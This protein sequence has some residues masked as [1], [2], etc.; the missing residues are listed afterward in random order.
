MPR[1]TEFDEY[2]EDL[3]VEVLEPEDDG[4]DELAAARELVA[5][6]D[7]KRQGKKDSAKPR[8]NRAQRRSRPAG[9]P[10][11]TDRLPKK[12]IRA[13]ETDPD[14]ELVITLFDREY[15]VRRGDL[16]GNWDYL[17]A[18]GEQNYLTMMIQIIGSDGARMFAADAK[19][20]GVKPDAG[21][22]MFFEAFGGELGM[23][24]GNS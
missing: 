9:A 18:V 22:K 5:A 23:T 2:D 14:D 16:A 3:E 15:R 20:N 11:P 17:L 24:A 1:K 12:S 6:A 21:L 7:A 19:A 8:G 10:A 4:A 13:R